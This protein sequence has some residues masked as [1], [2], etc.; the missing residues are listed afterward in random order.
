MVEDSHHDEAG[1]FDRIKDPMAAV[2]DTAQVNIE[3]I[4][5]CA[6]SRKIPDSVESGTETAHIVICLTCSELAIAEQS[7]LDQ[8]S[9][10]GLAQPQSNH[11]REDTWQ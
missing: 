2:N 9:L 1:A 11:L 3:T 6:E 5:A 7:D 4:D 8:V 10:R